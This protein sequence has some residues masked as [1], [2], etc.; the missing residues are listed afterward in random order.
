MLGIWRMTMQ[1]RFSI[2]VATVISLYLT[3][4]AAP[5][6]AIDCADWNS[7]EFFETATA[8]DVADCIRTGADLKARAMLGMTPLHHA[9]MANENP[10]VITVLVDAGADLDA[11]EMMLGTTPLHHAAGHNEHPAVITA[12]ADAG[13][14]LAARDKFGKTPLHWAAE[15]N[16]NPAVIAM[17]LDTGAD[18]RALDRFGKTPWDYVKDRE[19]LK[20]SDAHRRLD[21][22]RF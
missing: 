11:R 5:M 3:V 17:L 6:T 15:K 14:D 18:L 13:A 9:A 2:Q 22:N 4:V 1:P 16:E 7:Q 12:L 21:E 19:A 8:A 20:D 10:A